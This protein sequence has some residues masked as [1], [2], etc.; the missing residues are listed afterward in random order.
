[1]TT[2]TAVW[3]F[4]VSELVVLLSTAFVYLVG[5]YLLFQVLLNRARKLGVLGHY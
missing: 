2:G 5:G 1:M 4:P 3:Q